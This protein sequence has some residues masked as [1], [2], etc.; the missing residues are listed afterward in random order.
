MTSQVE[1]TTGLKRGSFGIGTFARHGRSFPA[2][3]KPAGDVIELSRFWP[4]THALFD[5]WR[6]SFDRLVDLA[7]HSSEAA[8][9]LE[10]VTPLPPLAH[11]QILG[12]GGNSG[13][14]SPR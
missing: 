8:F 7:A 13:S 11:P 6:H 4:D 10:A 12:A 1:P 3:V 9:D 2:L 14:T 5:D